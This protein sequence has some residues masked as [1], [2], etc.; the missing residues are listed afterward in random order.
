MLKN[1]SDTSELRQLLIAVFSTSGTL[2]GLSMTLVGIINFRSAD[3]RTQTIADD[4][5]LVS[6]VGFL[7]VCYLVFFTL[8]RLQSKRLR[9]WTI[10]IDTTFLASMTLLVLAGFVVLYQFGWGY[11]R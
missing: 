2:A 8:R 5:F 9:A 7:V 3:S 6:G 4:M 10:A 1:V 11:S